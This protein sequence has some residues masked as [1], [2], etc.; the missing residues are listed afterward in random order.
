ME[1]SNWLGRLFGKKS[2]KSILGIN[3]SLEN[4]LQHN[5][6]IG[7]FSLPTSFIHK[8][9]WAHYANSHR[10]FCVEYELEKLLDNHVYENKYSF[11][12]IYSS[13]PLELGLTD[14]PSL[15]KNNNLIQK[16]F[17]CKLKDW[18]YEEEYRIVTDDFGRYSYDFKAVE[19]IY[20]GLKMS[21]S[22]KESIMNRLK[23]RG[24]KYYQIIQIGNKYELDVVLV[25]N[26]DDSEL[27]YLTQIPEEVTKHKSVNYESFEKYYIKI[28][29]KAEIKIALES[30]ISQDQIS[31]LSNIFKEHLF[32]GAERIFIFYYLES[33]GRDYVWATSHIINGEMEISI[34]NS[35]I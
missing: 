7:I 18:E 4:L 23:G 21:D 30:V 17:G 32:Q 8:L 14:I 3:E 15:S 19:A 27:N 2:Q 20:F 22:Q 29:K 5:K 13:T 9:L 16:L 6:R 35:M 33:E 1:Q 28:S 26:I 31:W 34:K 24:I 10:G 25:K 11:P 12:V